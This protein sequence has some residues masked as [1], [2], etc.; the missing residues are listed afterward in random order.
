MRRPERADRPQERRGRRLGRPP[1]PHR[2][3]AKDTTLSRWR[4]GFE[5]RWGC[6]IDPVVDEGLS[7]L[8]LGAFA[9]SSCRVGSNGCA[10]I[11]SMMLGIPEVI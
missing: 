11:L 2:L 3:E 1:R 9:A 7:A 10:Q 8:H 4:H 5:S 6:Q